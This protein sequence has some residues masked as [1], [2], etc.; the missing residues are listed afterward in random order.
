MLWN[1]G[2]EDSTLF[3]EGVLTILHDGVVV[4]LSAVKVTVWIQLELI[5]IFGA[6]VVEVDCDVLVSVRSVLLVHEAKC[7]HQL[8][9]GSSRVDTAIA[10]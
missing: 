1:D 10:E 5:G 7:V 8:V 6:D 3:T 2:L 9:C 4:I